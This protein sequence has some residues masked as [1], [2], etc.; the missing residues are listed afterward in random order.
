MKTMKFKYLFALAAFSAAALA[1]CQNETKYTPSIYVTEAQIDP[2]RTITISQVGQT[3]EFSVSSSIV[4]EK[5]THVTLEACPEMIGHYNQL[6]GR[7]CK[8]LEEYEF[9]QKQV[10][11]KAGKNISDVC[12]VAVNQTL[13]A[14]TF[15]CLPVRIASTDGDMPILEPSSTLYL[16]FRAP[17]HGKGV[18]ITGSN[19]YIIPG[20]YLDDEVFAPKIKQD[21]SDLP[22]LTLECRVMVL[23]FQNNDPWI[24]SIMGLEGNVCMRF[25]DVKIGKDVFQ[26]CNGDYQP[27][28]INNP[29]ATNQWYHVAA[30]WGRQSLKLYID[31]KF[32]TETP[33]QGERVDISQKQVWTGYPSL[34]F[35]LGGSSNYNSHRPLNGYLAECRVWTRA[36]NNNEIAN[37][38]ELVIVDPKSEGLLSYWKM[39]QSEQVSIYE[40]TWRKT[41][42]NKIVDQTE[43]GYDAYGLLKEPTYIEAVW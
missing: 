29:C 11:I 39:D 34:S 43:N 41:L 40:G 13:E 31:G 28:A 8:P 22:E 12:S 35:S 6:Y 32:I 19:I 5:D 26:V 7:E 14:G 20:Y 9:L 38:K 25:G 2:A 3:T 36:L 10:T 37:L 1:G 17:V 33:H 21:I 23:G 27:A 16:V 18:K 42:Q 30:V 4:T 15:Y 24:T